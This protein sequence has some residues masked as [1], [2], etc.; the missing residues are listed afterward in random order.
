MMLEWV[1]K[2]FFKYYKDFENGLPEMFI[3]SAMKQTTLVFFY[4]F[5]N[6]LMLGSFI[7]TQ[8]R[9]CS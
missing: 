2:F 3:Q 1:L 4:S 5:N 7:F 8:K 9:N 6:F